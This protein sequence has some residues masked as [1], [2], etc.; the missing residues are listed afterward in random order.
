[1]LSPWL[2]LTCILIYFAVLWGIAYYTSR[3]A[4][5]QSYFVGNK[6]SA[7]WVVAYGMIGTS[8]S[9]VT[10]MSVPGQVGAKHFAYFQIVIGYLIGYMV[11][12]YV[13]LPL[14]YRMNLTSIYSY[15]QD[16]F[17]VKSYKTG[18]AFF[19]LSRTMGATLRM[20]LVINAL[21]LFLL[22]AGVFYYSITAFVIMLMILLYTYEGGVK[23]IVWTDLLQ[24]TFM[25]LALV[26][27]V[28]FILSQLGMS[29]A[30]V[31]QA[32][33]AKGYT[34][35]FMTDALKGNFFLK[36]IIGGA[37]ITIT[38]TGLDQE[39]MQKNISCKNIGDAQKNMLTFSVILVVVNFIFLFLGGLLFIYAEKNAI[40]IPTMTDDLFPTI[41]LQH[42]P[43]VISIIFIIGLISALFPSADGA[44]T[45]LTASFSIDML[46]LHTPNKYTEAQQ[47]ST[48]YRVHLA[49]A[50]LFFVLC[51]VFKLLNQ[52]ALIDILLEVAGYTYGPLLGLFMFGIM[53]QHKVQDKLVPWVCIAAPTLSYL[54]NIVVN[55][56]KWVIGT[57]IEAMLPAWS[58]TYTIGLEMLLIN[59]LITF[60]GLYLT[61]Q[62]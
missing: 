25:L 14:Y 6:S 54:I 45:A 55:K 3:G 59:G 37:F 42:L 39:M 12:A 7:W 19:I 18:A 20:Y 58:G 46:G 60:A 51:I 5:N 8:L 40:A 30:E 11:V 17:G 36:Q 43:P 57:S 41:S 49:F 4:N 52:R 13:L 32:F 9:G 61:R 44:L 33:S 53:T 35:V 1:M 24:T 31:L 56:P 62:R 10:F 22:P 47:K 23:S 29:G 28:G 38:M 21:Q 34:E 16:R 48:R 2:V 50:A 26:V 15:L 27:V